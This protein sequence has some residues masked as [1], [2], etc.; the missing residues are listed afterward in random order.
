ML[1]EIDEHLA[2][3]PFGT[4][5][6]A[7]AILTGQP[8]THSDDHDAAIDRWRELEVLTGDPHVGRISRAVLRT[9]TLG[10]PDSP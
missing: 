1:A 5:E 3:L 6:E 7:T 4:V 8:G 2:A 9:L 10:R